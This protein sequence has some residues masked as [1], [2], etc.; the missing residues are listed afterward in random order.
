MYVV[1]FI[2]R[3]KDLQREHVLKVATRHQSLFDALTAPGMPVQIAVILARSVCMPK[4]IHLS[5]G[6]K[7]EVTTAGATH[8]D[9]Q[10]R[11]A[12]AK[13]LNSTEL[14]SESSP[15]GRL[16]YAQMTLP[17]R[18][19][20]LGLTSL[21]RIAPLAYMSSI[22]QAAQDLLQY[23]PGM[24]AHAQRIRNSARSE[25]Q[26]AND[27]KRIADLNRHAPAAQSDYVPPGTAADT[28][29]ALAECLEYGKQE[30]PGLIESNIAAA[31][32]AAASAAMA[33]AAAADGDAAAEAGHAAAA[34]AFKAADRL[35]QGTVREFFATAAALPGDTDKMQS[36]LSTAMHLKLRDAVMRA[37][38]TPGQARLLS[39]AGPGSSRAFL[40]EPRDD[41]HSFYHRFAA[42]YAYLSRLGLLATESITPDTRCICGTLI[43]SDPAHFKTCTKLRRLGNLNMHNHVCRT[44]NRLAEQ[45][46]LIAQG[47]RTLPSGKKTDGEWHGMDQVYGWDF[48]STT[49]MAKS[50]CDSASKTPGYAIKV[51]EFAKYA[52]YNVECKRQGVA[53]LPLVMEV[54]GTMSRTVHSAAEML[55][56]YGAT[57]G[58][59]SPPSKQ[60]IL[61][62]LA[63]ALQKGQMLLIHQGVA[64]APRS[65]PQGVQVSSRRRTIRSQVYIVYV[66]FF[67]FFSL[68]SCLVP[69]ITGISRYLFVFCVNGSKHSPIDCAYLSLYSF[70][71]ASPRRPSYALISTASAHHHHPAN[72]REVFCVMYQHRFFFLFFISAS[73]NLPAQASQQ[74]AFFRRLHHTFPVFSKRSSLSMQSTPIAPSAPR[75]SPERQCTTSSA[76]CSSAV[77]LFFGRATPWPSRPPISIRKTESESRVQRRI[78]WPLLPVSVASLFSAFHVISAIHFTHPVFCHFPDS[79]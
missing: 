28:M 12:V 1:G 18:H 30:A 76:R 9:R 24:P 55:A 40:V 21:V 67:F 70:S 8:V 64:V 34:A 71:F 48:S 38:D 29:E 37:L 68:V 3:D 45:C 20:G 6:M 16:A 77:S 49:A 54:H 66:C 27:K 57:S 59:P 74:N 52:K 41:H 62:Q 60:G 61:N 13:L 78:F 42:A 26:A 33:S 32:A 23:F 79:F 25:A 11:V 5:R 36:S 58:A 43:H 4:L 14:V 39:C 72:A 50:V 7:P 53:F 15:R 56:E 73:S 2:G 75:R 63:V 46:G 10:I 31:T 69:A 35:L 65:A 44:W 47:E 17:L 19:G 51:R 22:A